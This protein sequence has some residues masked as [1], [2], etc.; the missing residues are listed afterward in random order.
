MYHVIVDK[1]H[2][3]RSD[4]SMLR[5]VI[6]TRP[7]CVDRGGRRHSVKGWMALDRTK[8]HAFLRS[9]LEAHHANR[10]L[11]LAVVTGHGDG[12]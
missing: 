11:Y 2:A 8:R 6:Q 4:L 3:M 9:C 12:V 10:R 1:Y 7:C 5:H